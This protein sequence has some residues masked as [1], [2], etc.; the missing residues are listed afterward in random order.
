MPSIVSIRAKTDA[1]KKLKQRKT[2][3]AERARAIR[4]RKGATQRVIDGTFGKQRELVLSGAKRFVNDSGRRAGKT[5]GWAAKLY[6]TGI[7]PEAAGGLS[8]YCTSSLARSDKLL[9][10]ELVKMDRVLRLGIERRESNSEIFYL[11]PNSPYP[12]KIWLTGIK[13]SSE[14]DKVRGPSY[15]GAVVDECQGLTKFLRA[16]VMDAIE[17]ALADH[18]GWLGLSGTPNVQPSG[19][20]HEFCRLAKENPSNESDYHHFHWDMRDNPYMGNVEKYIQGLFDRYG[21]TWKTPKFMREYLGIWCHDSESLCYP[22]T[23]ERNWVPVLPQ[24]DWE[25][26]IGVDLGIT[27]P[28]AWVVVAYSRFCSKIYVVHVEIHGGMSPKSSAEKTLELQ[29]R[30]GARTIV[31]DKGGL[32]AAM[33]KE[34]SDRYG[35]AAIAA[36]KVDTAGQISLVAGEIGAGTIVLVGEETKALADEWSVLPWNDDRSAHHDSYEDHASDA[37]R[38]IIRYVSPGVEPEEP[39]GL[40]KLADPEF[41]ALLEH[42]RRIA[43]LAG[44]C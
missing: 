35:I 37:A 8:V 7:Q 44:R 6:L 39:K 27:E 17:P 18:N 21:W 24:G 1:L 38:Y 23:R 19:D 41:V 16:L 43:R 10:A 31:A 15:F 33:V 2:I 14:V 34:W 40:V 11:I 28:C 22:Y 32:G 20:W 3:E 9:G 13:D 42:Q 30:F 12:H 26:A 4:D 29:T 5:G 36:K 25:F